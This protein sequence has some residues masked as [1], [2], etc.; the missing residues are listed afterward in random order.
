MLVTIGCFAIAARI[1]RSLRLLQEFGTPVVV[2]ILMIV[3]LFLYIIPVVSV[4][5][6]ARFPNWYFHPFPTALLFFV[7]HLFVSRI[8]I[9]HLERAG[10]SRVQEIERAIRDSVWLG[11]GGIG[12]FGVFWLISLVL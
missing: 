3:T 4:P 11:Y 9:R 12:Y 1:L 8:P 7:P 2:S 6:A 5:A 10:T